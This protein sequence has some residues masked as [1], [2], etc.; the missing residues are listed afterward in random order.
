MKNIMPSGPSPAEAEAHADT[1]PVLLDVGK[2]AKVNP[3]ARFVVITF[4]LGGV[5]PIDRRLS[6]YRKG[7]K[8]AEVKITGPQRDVNTIGD[9]ISGEVQVNDE[10]RSE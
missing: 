8:V 10:V 1:G 7:A 9:I 4:P 2:I 3:S 5:P 6:V